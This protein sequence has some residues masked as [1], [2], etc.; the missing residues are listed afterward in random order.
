MSSI[1]NI[2]LSLAAITFSS[3]VFATEIKASKDLLKPG[4]F[5]GYEQGK[6]KDFGSLRGPSFSFHLETDYPVGIMGSLT[7]MKNDWDYHDQNSSTS[8]SGEQ[9][10][11]KRNAEYYSAMIGPTTR[12]NDIISLYALAGV[13][14]TRV[15]LVEGGVVDSSTSSNE[16]AWSAGI[17]AKLTD[18]LALRV[19]YEGSKATFNEKKHPMDAFV[20]NL[21]YRF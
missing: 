3:A 11:P 6:L 18:N 1:R 9:K 4:L 5:L 10:P 8:K 7:A 17:M 21:G 2:A 16:F 15:K 14:H 13:S 20:I 19:G 12:L